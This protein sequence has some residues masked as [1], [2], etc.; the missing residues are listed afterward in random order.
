MVTNLGEPSPST[1]PVSRRN[2][3][4]SSPPGIQSLEIGMKVLTTL[5]SFSSAATLTELAEAADMDLSTC[6]R[7]LVSLLNTGMVRQEEQSGKYDLGEHLYLLGLRT[8]ARGH[9]VRASIDR[10]L[11]LNRELDLTV[12]VSVWGDLGPTVVAWFDRSSKLICNSYIGSVYPML[13]TAT[14]RVFL[15]YPPDGQAM[16]RAAAEL[17]VVG[18]AALSASQ[19]KRIDALVGSVR[20]Q[21]MGSTDGDVIPGLSALAVPAFDCQG[22]PGTVIGIIAESDALKGA[23][24]QRVSKALR[25]AG[26]DVSSSHGFVPEEQGAGSYAEWLE[27]T[28]GNAVALRLADAPAGRR[29]PGAKRGGR[30]VPL[31]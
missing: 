16:E 17:G 4:K 13:S 24:G 9:I 5:A 2:R 3:E 23:A 14:G 26:S 19:H 11:A 21:G 27:R 22:R 12:I 28:W 29:T 20:E 10:A 25:Q 1:N 6:R 7:Y 15:A 31:G 18:S 8:L 30:A